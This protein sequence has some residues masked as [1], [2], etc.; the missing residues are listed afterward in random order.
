V[1]EHCAGDRE[2]GTHV[3]TRHLNH[4]HARFQAPVF[5]CGKQY[6]FCRSILYTATR[7]EELRLGDDTSWTAVDSIQG[8]QR[9]LGD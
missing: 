6:R 1:T 3:A 2:A 8:N 7:L 9:C 5:A 4:R